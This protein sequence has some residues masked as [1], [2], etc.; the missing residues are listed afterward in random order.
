VGKGVTGRA[1]RQQRARMRKAMALERFVAKF[2]ASL[3]RT[4]D[5]LMRHPGRIAIA[6]PLS[7][8]PRP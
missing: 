2:R 5:A 7:G 1:R 8:T 3:S 6:L 4:I